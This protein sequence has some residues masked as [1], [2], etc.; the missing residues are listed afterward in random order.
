MDITIEA[1]KTFFNDHKDDEAVKTYL[2]GLRSTTIDSVAIS[3]FLETDEGKKILQPKIDQAVSRAIETYKEKTLPGLIDDGVKAKIKEVHPDETPEQKQIREQNERIDKLEK[4]DKINNLKDLT[5]KQF[6]A[7][8]ISEFNVL[9]GLFLGD[10]EE[11]TK[12]KIVQFKAILDDYVKAR[13]KEAIPSRDVVDSKAID[14]SDPGFKN[15][16]SV[17]HLNLTEQGRIYREDP[18]LAEK[19]KAEAQKAS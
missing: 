12:G 4:R 16:F 5:F 11:S 2:S 14:S 18:K 7:D 10:D 15:P 13:I 8:K 6:A 9:A 19:L 3:K 17:K 1:I